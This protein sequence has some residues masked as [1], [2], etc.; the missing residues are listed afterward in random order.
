MIVF[1][2]L[3]SDQAAGAVKVAPADVERFASN[4]SFSVD[5]AASKTMLV[6]PPTRTAKTIN[7]R[8]SQD[9][10][11]MADCLP[12]SLTLSRVLWDTANL[13]PELCVAENRPFG[14]NHT[15]K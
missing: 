8:L 15:W 7:F 12:T 3:R 9:L 14:S 6:S 11:A 5:C 4:A 13:V 1:A 10:V 2:W